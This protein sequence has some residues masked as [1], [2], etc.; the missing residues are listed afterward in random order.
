MEVGGIVL[1]NDGHLILD[2]AS[3]QTLDPVLGEIDVGVVGGCQDDQVCGQPRSVSIQK[4]FKERNGSVHSM[5]YGSVAAVNFYK[6]NKM[7]N[8]H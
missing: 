4:P 2:A 6:G 8:D 1:C 3:S 5:H 7:E